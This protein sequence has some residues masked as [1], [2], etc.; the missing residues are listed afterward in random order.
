MKPG[1]TGTQELQETRS[2]RNPGATGT[3]ELN[4]IRRY[5]NPGET[6]EETRRKKLGA[7]VVQ[8]SEM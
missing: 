5:R 6:Q 7:V 2:Y 8:E 1:A 4:K 3:Q